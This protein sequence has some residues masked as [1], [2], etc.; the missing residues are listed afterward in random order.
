MHTRVGAVYDVNKPAIIHINVV[1]L[2][3]EVADLHGRLARSDRNRRTAHVGVSRRRRDIIA[4]L[5]GEER[6]PD[7]DRAYPCVEPRDKD[8]FP[9]INVGEILATS[10]GAEATTPVAEV[11]A[12]LIDLIIR[13]DR[14][15]GLVPGGSGSDVYKINK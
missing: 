5:L 8:Q 4:Y 11:T 2:N 10:M 3:S 13:D 14:R 7:V 12:V 1:S 6:I 9:V 15:L